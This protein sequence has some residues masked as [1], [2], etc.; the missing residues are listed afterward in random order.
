ML[1][2]QCRRVGSRTTATSVAWI[3]A[4]PLRNRQ[5]V[6]PARLCFLFLSSPAVRKS[7]TCNEENTTMAVDFRFLISFLDLFFSCRSVLFFRRLQIGD[8]RL[9]W[10]LRGCSG[11]GS[12]GAVCRLLLEES[13]VSMARKRSGEVGRRLICRCCFAVAGDRLLRWTAKTGRD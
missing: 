3:Q 2:E 7:I 9:R 10:P 13:P 11:G 5:P 4:P 8:G 6:D 12:V 1:H